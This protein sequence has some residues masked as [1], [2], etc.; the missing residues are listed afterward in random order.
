MNRKRTRISLHKVWQCNAEISKEKLFGVV[1]MINR[2]RFRVDLYALSSKFHCCYADLYNQAVI[3]YDGNVYKC[4]ARDFDEK[5]S[6][7]KLSFSGQIYWDV[8]VVKKRLGL[9]LPEYCRKCVLLPSCNGIC[10]QN[11]LENESMKCPYLK[12][13][14]IEDIVT[15]NIKQQLIARTYEKV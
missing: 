12:D 5:N 13:M 15:L 3:N 7:G 10:S 6:C 2:Y 9:E 11:L 8:E 4:T 1:N 14:T